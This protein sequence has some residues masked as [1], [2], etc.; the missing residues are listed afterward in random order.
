MTNN[1]RTNSGKGPASGTCQK[2]KWRMERSVHSAR[3][4][5]AYSVDLI[6]F[7]DPSANC[8]DLVS[9]GNS[10][11]RHSLGGQGYAACHEIST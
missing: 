5:I 6:R 4:A 8:M 9:L 2:A 1:A 10:G 7:K 3:Y 11:L